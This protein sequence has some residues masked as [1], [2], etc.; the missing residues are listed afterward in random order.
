MIHRLPADVM[1]VLMREAA[2]DIPIEQSQL[3]PLDDAQTKFRERMDLQVRQARD[4]GHVI[5][6]TPEFPG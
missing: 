2:L 4:A 6:W 5:D 3:A 1:E